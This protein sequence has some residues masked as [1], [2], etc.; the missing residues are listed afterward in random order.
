MEVV[1]ID[2]QGRIYLPSSI[3]S[4]LTHRRF[5]VIIEGENMLLIPIKP[6][7]ERYYGIAGRPKYDTA[8][9]IDG[10]VRD[11]TERI[12]REDIH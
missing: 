10:A 11:E 8:E 4:K 7:V 6:S 12:L 9:E 1:E 5:R 2:S 3:R